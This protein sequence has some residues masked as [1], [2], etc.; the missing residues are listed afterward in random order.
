[1]SLS[2]TALP[3]CFRRSAAASSAFS[4]FTP[5]LSSSFSNSSLPFGLTSLSWPYTSTK[6]S[7]GRRFAKK[8]PFASSFIW[9]LRCW[10]A[11]ACFLSQF[12]SS[13]Y[14]R[15]LRPCREKVPKP[16]AP[17]GNIC[18]QE[19][20]SYHREGYPPLQMQATHQFRQ[21]A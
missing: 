11:F 8:L 21:R 19:K 14:L 18:L 20:R 7:F 13:G 6:S 3:S 5:S 4:L 10:L 16:I 9:S 17:L 12:L 2:S 15:M 1:M